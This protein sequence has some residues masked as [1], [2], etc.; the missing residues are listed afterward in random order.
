MLGKRST[1]ELHPQLFFLF[2]TESY[3]VVKAGL[4]LTSLLLKYPEC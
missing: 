4:E 2:K 3:C 1:P